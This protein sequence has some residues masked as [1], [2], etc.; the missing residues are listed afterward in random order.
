MPPG[1]GESPRPTIASVRPLTHDAHAAD[2][3]GH[4]LNLHPR[5]VCDQCRYPAGPARPTGSG[6]HRFVPDPRHLEESLRG[7]PVEVR[8]N[9]SANAPLVKTTL[10]G[11]SAREI[12]ISTKVTGDS[13]DPAVAYSPAENDADTYAQARARDLPP[14]SRLDDQTSASVDRDRE[15]RQALGR[16]E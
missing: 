8:R 1:V 10:E 5:R 16:S 12:V 7:G 14:Q 6:T 4:E 9:E 15:P 13:A 11:R 3:K 2:Q